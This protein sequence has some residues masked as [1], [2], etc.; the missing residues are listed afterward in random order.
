MEHADINTHAHR[1]RVKATLEKE[2]WRLRYLRRASMHFSAASTLSYLD[3]WKFR[4]RAWAEAR[5][6]YNTNPYPLHHVYVARAK[7]GQVI[8]TTFI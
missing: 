2:G 6:T 8:S 5:D 4:S 1:Y 3:I 7:I